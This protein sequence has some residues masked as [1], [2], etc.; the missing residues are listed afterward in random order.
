MNQG[1]PLVFK[2][3]GDD[4]AT[5][6]CPH[7]GVSRT[8]N[9]KKYRGRDAQ[10][11]ITCSCGKKFVSRFE[12]RDND[13]AVETPPAPSPDSPS[14]PIAFP[15]GPDGVIE[16]VC[17]ECSF[18]KRIPYEKVREANG[19]VSIHCTC[20][21]SFPCVFEVPKALR[22]PPRDDGS[23]PPGIEPPP[24]ESSGEQGTPGESGEPPANEESDSIA[25]P[26]IFH[27]DST[28]YVSILCPVCGF[29]KRVPAENFHNSPGVFNVNCKCGRKFQAR[30]ETPPPPK[31]SDIVQ[32]TEISSDLIEVIVDDAVLREPD[33][34]D[35][36]FMHTV[37]PNSDGVV[38]FICPNCGYDRALTE[39]EKKK[40]K[41]FFGVD[42]KCGKK[43]ECHVEYRKNYRKEVTLYG[44]Y[45]QEES[46]TSGEIQ[47]KDISLGGVGFYTLEPHQLQL[48][49]IIKV[50]FRLD[51][52]K[53]TTINRP[54][55]VRFI[56][57]KFIG[58]QFTE[59]QLYE[60]DLG[61]YLRN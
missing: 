9:V 14:P 37:Y 50:R 33:V 23:L 1:Q 25:G 15:V 57:D 39:D 10:V 8:V 54:V 4:T 21:I 41:T 16:I 45:F 38:A 5:V 49:D 43:Y 47:V 24:P 7:C 44:D 31:A 48:G 42:C 29:G 51:D 6:V 18:K 2:A 34:T 13:S 58:A 30:V 11:G 59:K 60:K 27:P 46:W 20:G 17:P 56:K 26:V 40:Y 55:E 28:G 32:V 19:P 12:F 36:K 61:F 52:L 35:T 22:E 3:D 53:A